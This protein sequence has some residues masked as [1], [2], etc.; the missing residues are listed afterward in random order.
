MHGVGQ[1]LC[2]EVIYIERERHRDDDN[3]DIIIS[4]IFRLGERGFKWSILRPL[5]EM[6][7]T[8][9]IGE[10]VQIAVTFRKH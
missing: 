7:H 1:V 4:D 3:R 2:D 8:R 9:E 6:E 5:N 10:S